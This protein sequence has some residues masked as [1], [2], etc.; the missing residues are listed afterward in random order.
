MAEP[1]ACLEVNRCPDKKFFSFRPGLQ[2]RVH[3]G[4]LFSLFLSQNI[5]CGYSKEPSQ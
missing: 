5:R 2:I 1:R 4:K 3:I